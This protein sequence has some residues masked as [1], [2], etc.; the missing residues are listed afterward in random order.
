MLRSATS[1]IPSALLAGAIAVLATFFVERF[2]GIVGGIL[3]TLPTTIVA[4][5]LGIYAQSVST[6]EFRRAMAFVPLG[7][8][9]N[10]AYLL[11]WR[12]LPDQ[13]KRLQVRHVLRSTIALASFAWIVAALVLIF[14]HDHYE[15]SV[16]ESVFFGGAATCV[17]LALGLYA[18]RRVHSA[19]RGSHRVRLITYFMRGVGASVVVGAAILIGRSGLPL[20]SGLASVFP[21]IFTTIMVSTWLSQGEEVPAGAAGPM[22]LGTLSISVF[23]LL[24]CWWMPALGPIIGAT[25]AWCAS[26]A[27]VSIPGYLYIRSHCMVSKDHEQAA[28]DQSGTIGTASNRKIS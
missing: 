23:A 13:L 3:S 12:W 15:P 10:A 16:E 26:T 22:T 27:C 19:P 2:G 5:A 24:A 14:A 8:L 17:G 18:T 7:I 25:C 4:Y 1:V 9:L 21:I 20:A 6:D 28:A 11:L